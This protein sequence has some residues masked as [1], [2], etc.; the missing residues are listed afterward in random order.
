MAKQWIPQNMTDADITFVG[1]VQHLMPAYDDIPREFKDCGNEWVR[2]V[3]RWFFHGIV[4]AEFAPKPGIDPRQPYATSQPSCARGSQR[5]STK[6][7]HAR[8]CYPSGSVAYGCRRLRQ[9]GADQATTSAAWVGHRRIL[10][11]ERYE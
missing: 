8:F 4:G 7:R 6:Q 5:M 3:S 10:E 9:A 11:G 1:S 2:V